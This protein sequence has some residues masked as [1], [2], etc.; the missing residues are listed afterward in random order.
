MNLTP[1]QREQVAN[2]VKRFAADLQLTS[3][4]K[5]KLQTAF[6]DAR[7]KLGD[8]MKEHPG[9]TKAD[10]VKQV[11]GQRDQIRQRV[12]NFL[13]PEQLKKWDSEIIK[14]KEFL[15]QPMA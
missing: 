4:Q 5:E 9:V 15:G 13:N 6:Q 14:A 3:D 11:A 2:E 10:I 12:V 1:E 7:G 8:Y